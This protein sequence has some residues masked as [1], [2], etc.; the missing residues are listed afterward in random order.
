MKP[1]QN[2]NNMDNVKESNDID[3]DSIHIFGVDTYQYSHGNVKGITVEYSIGYEEDM[4][5]GNI[6]LY[7][8]KQN[9]LV[10]SWKY[11]NEGDDENK[12][13]LKA[14]MNK[15]INKTV[16]YIKPEKS[17]ITLQKLYDNILDTLDKAQ[18]KLNSIDISSSS[19]E[20]EKLKKFSERVIQ[21]HN[22]I[23]RNK[24]Y[25]LTKEFENEDDNSGVF[26]NLINNYLDSYNYYASKVLKEDF[27][28]DDIREYLK[29]ANTVVFQLYTDLANTFNLDC[30]SEKS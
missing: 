2:I 28:I 1:N 23:G 9:D 5:F 25:I 30:E 15:F 18:K 8:N 4:E 21:Y 26:N 7:F 13:I 12:T 29:F 27:T 14:V 16:K 20:V 17:N 24:I 6:S 19:E 11:Y 10:P 22:N 3:I